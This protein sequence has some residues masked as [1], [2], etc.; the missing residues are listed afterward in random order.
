LWKAMSLAKALGVSSASF[1]A[2]RLRFE[3]SWALPTGRALAFVEGGRLKLCNPC[4]M[5]ITLHVH[6]QYH[7]NQVGEPVR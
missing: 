7:R 3:G 2:L 5:A 6:G 4:Q 1:V